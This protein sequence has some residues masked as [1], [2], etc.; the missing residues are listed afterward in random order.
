MPRHSPRFVSA[1]AIFSSSVRGQTEQTQV[2]WQLAYLAQ[3]LRS[4][5]TETEAQIQEGKTVV[6][7]ISPSVKGNY[8]TQIVPSDKA[9]HL[10]QN[11]RN[12]FVIPFCS[13]VK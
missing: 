1:S 13:H 10:Q 8:K 4:P 12:R 5:Q 9:G 7:H 2:I 3:F 6:T 11:V